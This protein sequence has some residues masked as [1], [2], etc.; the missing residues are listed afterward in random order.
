MKKL[1]LLLLLLIPV[2][3][4]AI[5]AHLPTYILTGDKENQ[6]KY[7]VNI[8]HELVDNTGLFM[9]YTMLAKWNIYDRSSPF[10]FYNHSPSIFW[11]SKKIG[12]IDFIRVIPYSHTSNGLAGWESQ[13]MDRYF[14]EAQISFGEKINFGIR[15]KSGGYYNYSHKEGIPVIRRYLGF[16]ETEFFLQTKSTQGFIG[17]ERLYFKGE[18]T[19]KYYWTESGLSFRIITKHFSPHIYIQKYFGYSEFINE[20]WKKTNATR[21]GLLFLY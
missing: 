21:I 14:G 2:K 1:L 7:Q 5:S 16:F 10:T 17:H 15:E 13:S 11:Q 18:F 9:S 6:L 4:W 12:Y 3:V 20:Y 8:D 19:K